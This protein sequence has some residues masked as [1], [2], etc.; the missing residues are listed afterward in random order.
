[1]TA[2]A[3]IRTRK[4]IKIRAAYNLVL[5]YHLRGHASD[6]NGTRAIVCYLPALRAG[7]CT[8]PH[9]PAGVS[10]LRCGAGAAAEKVAA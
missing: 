6:R 3:R 9:N 10:A 4:A 8:S 7:I 1:V 5:G 2:K